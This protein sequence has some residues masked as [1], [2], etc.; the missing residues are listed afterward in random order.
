MAFGLLTGT[1]DFPEL[2]TR[3]CHAT[4][5]HCHH[6]ISLKNNAVNHTLLAGIPSTLW[7]F[8]THTSGGCCN[9][10]DCFVLVGDIRLPPKI[11]TSPLADGSSHSSIS[12]LDSHK[13]CRHGGMSVPSSGSVRGSQRYPASYQHSHLHASQQHHQRFHHHHHPDSSLK[14]PEGGSLSGSY[15]RLHGGVVG[16]VPEATGSSLLRYG[17][18]SSGYATNGHSTGGT[19][20]RKHNPDSS[21]G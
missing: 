12:R 21:S 10:V 18:G 15:R 11:L 3:P 20:S 19:G 16:S 6:L 5:S 8:K 1:P 9:G 7:P 14:S 4:L 17:S 2:P 13:F